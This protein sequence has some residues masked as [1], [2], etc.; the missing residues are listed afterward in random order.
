ISGT[1]T[2]ADIGRFGNITI[3]VSDGLSKARVGPFSID[4]VAVGTGSATI[5]WAAPTTRTD[6]TPLLDLAGYRLYWGRSA[7]DYTRSTTIDNP[8]VTTYVVDGLTSGTWY[9]AAT[10]LDSTGLESRFSN[11][12]SSTVQ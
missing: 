8:G 7:G 5:V 3:E 6:G 12:I 10:A 11:A 2:A 4:V 1:P 9:F